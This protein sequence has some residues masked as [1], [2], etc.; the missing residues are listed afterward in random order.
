MPGMRKE[1]WHKSRKWVNFFPPMTDLFISYS[2]RDK[3]FIQKLHQT[4]A[5]QGR[6][7][8]V[9]YDDIPPAV[10]WREEIRQNLEKTNA[11]VFVLSP[12][13]SWCRR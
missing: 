12:G 13:L 4:L 5:E 7:I 8:W 6:D 2:R 11:V 10:D 1:S 3:N 9:D